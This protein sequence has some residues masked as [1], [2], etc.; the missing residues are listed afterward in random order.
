MAETS[1]NGIPDSI[2]LANGETVTQA[3]LIRRV[4]ERVYQLWHDEMRLSRERGSPSAPR[5]RRNT[6]R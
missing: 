5:I 4:T 1:A 2:R 3:E 6:H